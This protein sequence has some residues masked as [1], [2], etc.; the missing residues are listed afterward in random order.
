MH[1]VKPD[2]VYAEQTGKPKDVR[3]DWGEHRIYTGDPD[4]FKRF[5]EDENI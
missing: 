1:N 4:E 3:G 5:S 2:A